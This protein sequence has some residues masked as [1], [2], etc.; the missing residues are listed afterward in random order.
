MPHKSNYR[1]KATKKARGFLGTAK[2]VGLDFPKEIIK[3]AIV[4]GFV[5]KRVF[6]SKFKRKK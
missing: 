4:P 5:E 3:R 1:R 6:G 2:M